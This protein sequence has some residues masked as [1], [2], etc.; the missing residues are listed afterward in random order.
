MQFAPVQFVKELFSGPT[1][2]QMEGQDII[3]LCVT[4]LVNTTLTLN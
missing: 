4:F 3:I 1:Q 2:V